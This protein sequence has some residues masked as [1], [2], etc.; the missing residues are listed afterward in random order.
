VSCA[1]CAGGQP[2]EQESCPA[3]GEA[4][5]DFAA[6][7]V[8]RVVRRPSVPA[9]PATESITPAL[10]LERQEPPL[11]FVAVYGEP[12][13]GTRDTAA[14]F[15]AVYPLRKGDVFFAGKAAPSEVDRS[16]GKKVTPAAVHLFPFSEAY[17]HI[18]RRHVTIEFLSADEAQINDLSTN[19]LTL[20]GT[21]THLR[22]GPGDASKRHVLRQSELIILGVDLSGSHDARERDRATRYQ[23][24]LVMPGAA[25][26]RAEAAPDA[27]DART[28]SRRTRR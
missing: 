8:T 10:A 12:T 20:A 4:N 27:T 14:A 5:P 7:A 18:S 17:G 15:G 28:S 24:H 19:G 26:P 13:D 22:K 6:I 21:W 16:D 25:P 2:P 9:T 11:G 3:C 23:L 1:S